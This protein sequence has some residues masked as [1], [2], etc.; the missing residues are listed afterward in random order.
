MAEEKDIKG[1]I[2][3]IKKY[4]I[5]DGPGIR[6][7]VF[8]KGCPL[9]CKWCHNPESLLVKPE[10]A[11]RFAR[12]QAC[13]KCVEICPEHAIS[14]IN[15]NII[16]DMKKCVRC[17]ECTLVCLVCARE[18]VGRE[19]GVDEVM[20]EIRK[21]ICF[22][23][24]SG[25]GV[26]FSGGEPLIQ[27]EFLSALLEQCRNENIHTAI[28]TTCY[29]DAPVVLDIAAKTDLMLCDIKHLNSAK[30]KEYTGVDNKK[31]LSNIR[32]AADITE[33]VI[34]IPIIGGYNDD[35]ENLKTTA[36]WICGLKKPVCVD[37]LPYNSAG[38]EKTKRLGHKI[39]I[40]KAKTPED[41][42]LREIADMYKNE[43]GL[44]VKIDG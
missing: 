42:F 16:T 33:V 23:E 17:S 5:H 27:P 43:Y 8:F 37:I 21:D 2:F 6:T 20:A 41:K 35:M 19:V 34:R 4:A 39:S 1:T 44:T 25:G 38:A 36:E 40:I 9:R 24:E 11:I 31:I 30:H 14:N 10:P 22:Y 32:K 7:T 18:I 3:D 28:D 15:G 13:G 29:G 12:C 26:T